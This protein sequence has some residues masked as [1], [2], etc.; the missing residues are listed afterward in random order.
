MIAEVDR[1][2]RPEGKLIVRDNSETLEEVESMAKSL[3]WEVRM[4]YSKEN[5][6]L[7]F[8]QKTMWRPKEVEASLP[9]LS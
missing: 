1:I 2:L 5:E 3:T 8:V 9:S 6:G 7:L 4:T